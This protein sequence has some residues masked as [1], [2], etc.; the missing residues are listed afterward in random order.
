MVTPDLTNSRKDPTQEKITM[1]PYLGEEPY[2]PPYIPARAI[3]RIGCKTVCRGLNSV[4]VYQAINGRIMVSWIDLPL[5]ALRQ[6]NVLTCVII[7]MELQSPVSLL[8]SQSHSHHNL[9]KFV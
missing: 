8:K 3:V 4:D 5:S 2:L 9:L 6:Q 1:N 7:N